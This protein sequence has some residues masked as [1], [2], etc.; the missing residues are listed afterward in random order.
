[1]ARSDALGRNDA[2]VLGMEKSLASISAELYRIAGY[3]G[4][5]K[6]V[7]E[8]ITAAY[9]SAEGDITSYRGSLKSVEPFGFGNYYES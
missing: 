2:N 6:A 3:V 9:S 4:G 8:Q 7:L 5:L 1:M